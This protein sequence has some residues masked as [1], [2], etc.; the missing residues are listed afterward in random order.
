VEGEHFADRARL[1]EGVEQVFCVVAVI[2][3]DVRRGLNAGVHSR[4][5]RMFARISEIDANGLG[6]DLRGHFDIGIGKEDD[7]FEPKVEMV[8]HG[9]VHF[10]FVLDHD[11]GNGPLASAEGAS[12]RKSLSEEYR[13][14]LS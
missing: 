7:L 11:Q 5:Q 14:G 8:A 9:A 3:P 6:L 10:D 4:R 1:A 13:M 2:H 12:D